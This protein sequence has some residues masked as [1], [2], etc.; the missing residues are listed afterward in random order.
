MPSK[1]VQQKFCE[2]PQWYTCTM[3]EQ[4]P[5]P[6]GKILCSFQLMKKSDVDKV[7]E[8]GH[9]GPDAPNGIEP[10]RSPCRVE[11]SPG[12]L[13]LPLTPPGV[14]GAGDWDPEHGAVQ[15]HGRE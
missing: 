9:W 10:E 4:D 8:K 14:G 12:P 5:A 6:C 3:G 1:T 13:P 11:A 2:D 15:L 7:K